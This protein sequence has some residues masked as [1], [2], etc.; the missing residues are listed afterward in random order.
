MTTR[1]KFLRGTGTGLAGVMLSAPV[2]PGATDRIEWPIRSALDESDYW[3]QVRALYPLT[4][5]RAYMNTGGLG[6]AP[7]PVLD[8]VRR[9][10]MDLQRIS[11]HGHYMIMEARPPAA[12]F[13]GADPEEI[14][15]T[16]NATEGNATVASGLQ[17]SRGDEV[18]FESHAHPG[19]SIPWLS[20]AKRDGIKIKIF[21]PVP[22]SEAVNLQRLEDQ[23][24]DRTRVIQV[25]HVTAPT[26]IKF[27]VEQ[28]ARLAHDRGIWFHIDGAQS[29]GMFQFDLHEIGCDSFATSCHKWTCA[30]VGTGILYIKGDRLDEVYPTEAG[31]Y[32][33]H[34]YELP[35]QFEYNPTAQRYESGT[36]DATSVV[37][38]VAAM[39]F[40]DEIGLER[41]TSRDMALASYLQAALSEI[42]EV[43]ILSPTEGSLRT[44]MT[45]YK[46]DG[47]PYDELN[48][49]LAEEFS[50]RCRVVSERGLDA[51]RVSTHIFN[52]EQECDRVVEGTMA[53]ITRLRQPS[54]KY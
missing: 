10:M 13:L 52:F 53:A 46:V 35:D 29:A 31:A 34:G 47:V 25:S 6:P 11:E 28:I 32:S 27:P 5:E 2:I 23:I 12:D 24:T 17:M 41:V 42:P 22:N 3:R 7:Y 9:T 1:R 48:S 21:E 15:F 44:P 18:I 40:L 26:G 54:G 33:D 49:F 14:A 45:T 43:T 4:R 8:A 51:L 16:R 19:G 50:L 38:L 20:R 36:R 30:P 37:G 39:E